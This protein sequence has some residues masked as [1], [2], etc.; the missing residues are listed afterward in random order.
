VGPVGG[1]ARPVADAEIGRCSPVCAGTVGDMASRTIDDGSR[2]GAG[3]WRWNA[4][5]VRLVVT[6]LLVAVMALGLVLRFWLLFGAVAILA[7]ALWLIQDS[8]VQRQARRELEERRRADL[9]SRADAEHQAFLRGEP[10]GLY[11]QYEP[12]E[13]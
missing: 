7:V 10:R 3:G 9:R 8:A 12:P 2:Y 5:D 1:V 6:A 11:G 4:G 13:V